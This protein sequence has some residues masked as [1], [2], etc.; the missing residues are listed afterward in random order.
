MI[1]HHSNVLSADF[2]VTGNVIRKPR[3][4]GLDF[5]GFNFETQKLMLNILLALLM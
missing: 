4:P 1:G 2:C 5:A 3:L